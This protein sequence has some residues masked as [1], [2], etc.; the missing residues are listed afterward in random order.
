MRRRPES[1]N[2]GIASQPGNGRSVSGLETDRETQTKDSEHSII[3]NYTFPCYNEKADAEDATLIND[4]SYSSL[5]A[6]RKAA[7]R[8]LRCL[9]A[10]FALKLEPTASAQD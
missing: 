1:R 5:R 6:I 8:A 9:A 2:C 7:L 4:R 10:I 3:L